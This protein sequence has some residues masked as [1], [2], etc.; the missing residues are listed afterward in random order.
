MRVVALGRGVRVSRSTPQREGGVHVLQSEC[1]HDAYRSGAESLVSHVTESKHH[2]ER[3][4][5]AAAER[6]LFWVW[7]GALAYYDDA[8]DTHSIDILQKIQGNHELAAQ[9]AA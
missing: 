8:R 6:Q 3:S 7:A 4:F 1:S 9:I 2:E 5:S